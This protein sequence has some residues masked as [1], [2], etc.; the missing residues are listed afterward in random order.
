MTGGIE[1]SER[2]GRFIEALEAAR[3]QW[4]EQGACRGSSLDFT[5]SNAAERS[6]CVQVC[7]TCPVREACLEWA[8]E[9]GDTVAVLGGTDPSARRAIAR[10]RNKR[11]S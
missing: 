2:L 5:S 8:L 3:P 6:A 1:H 10:T 11:A 9:V 4:H 7:G